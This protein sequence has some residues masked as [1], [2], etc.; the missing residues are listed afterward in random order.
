M[1]HGHDELGR[2][3]VLDRVDADRDAAAVVLDGDRVVE[4]ND[5][6]DARAVA[7]EV[8]VDRVVDDLVDEVMQARAVIG[9]ADVHAGAL[10]DAF[11]A[12][13][14]ADRA[15]VVR[16]PRKSANLLWDLPFRRG[17]FRR[18]HVAYHSAT[19]S[20]REIIRRISRG[21]LAILDAVIGPVVGRARR[22]SRGWS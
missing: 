4:V 19:T 9:V 21:N 6:V 10:A 5:D 15:V 2:R 22:G 18:A 14:D 20:N 1:Q 8:L 7:R 16:R 13:Q 12:L 17:P 3:T 11:E